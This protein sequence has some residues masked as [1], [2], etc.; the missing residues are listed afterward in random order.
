VHEWVLHHWTALEKTECVPVKL[1]IFALGKKFQGYLPL[2]KTEGNENR[3]P[4][5]RYSMSTLRLSRS[6][7]DDACDLAVSAAF[8][9]AIVGMS[10]LRLS[11]SS[12]DDARDLA[13]SAAFVFFF[14]VMIGRYVNS[15]IIWLFHWRC[16]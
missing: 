5:I 13:V 1:A 8:V 10:S 6:S 12:T 11:R 16:P 14:F 3:R 9:F 4:T 2:W 7:T 15:E